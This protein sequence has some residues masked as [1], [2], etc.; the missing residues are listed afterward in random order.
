MKLMSFIMGISAP[1]ASCFVCMAAGRY[2]QSRWAGGQK[3]TTF[4]FIKKK[5]KIF[6]NSR[7]HS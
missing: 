2:G 3:E 4:F 6:N 7:R 5:Q 1:D